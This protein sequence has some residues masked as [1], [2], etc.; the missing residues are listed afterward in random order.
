[1]VIVLFELTIKPGKDAGYFDR[2]SQLYPE[3]EKV[4]GFV[5]VERFESLA[6]KGKYLAM[7]VWRD[8]DAVR[9][10]RG[11]TNHQ[12]AQ[13]RGKDEVFADYRVRVT[14][15]VREYGA[16]NGLLDAPAVPPEAQAAGE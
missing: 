5:S 6:Q 11:N 3:L 10:W 14:E 8:A 9:A 2:A 1:M 15:V 7:S 4:D 12:A 13:Q 16:E